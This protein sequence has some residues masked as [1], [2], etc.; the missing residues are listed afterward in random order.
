[1]TD[2]EHEMLVAEGRVAKIV[3][4][5]DIEAHLVKRVNILG[6]EV[7]KVKWT[8]RRNAP[9]RVVFVP[10]R[11]LKKWDGKVTAFSVCWQTDTCLP[12]ATIWVE[13]KRPGGK[14]TFP[15][16]AHERAQH[17]EHER[18]RALGQHVVVIDSYEGVDELLS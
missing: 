3:R 9:D 12:C 7:R 2:I 6:G 1:M 17:R 13:L 14:A 10:T 16:D 15:K 8:G 5:C 18:M 4:E 11:T